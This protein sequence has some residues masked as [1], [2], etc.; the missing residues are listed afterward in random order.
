MSYKD[1]INAVNNVGFYY[2]DYDIIS[3]SQVFLFENKLGRYG[4]GLNQIIKKLSLDNLVKYFFYII[5]PKR[6]IDLSSSE[7]VFVNDI[8]NM[9]MLLNTRILQK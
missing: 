3:L 8:Y 7:Y 2:K 6:D 4:L 5:N 9:S 1:E